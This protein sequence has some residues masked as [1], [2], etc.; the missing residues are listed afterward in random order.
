MSTN[1]DAQ[2]SQANMVRFERTI[3]APST[4]IWAN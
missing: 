1:P 4:T 2:F 3:H